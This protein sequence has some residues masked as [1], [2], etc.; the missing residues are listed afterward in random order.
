MRYLTTAAVA[1]AL[2]AS[3]ASASADPQN[4]N[5]QGA[6]GAHSG[7]GGQN[8]GQSG[9]SGGQVVGGHTGTQGVAHT[10]GQGGGA[11]P[12][13]VVNGQVHTFGGQGGQTN[14]GSRGPG[15]VQGSQTVQQSVG[16]SNG[17][18]T[19]GL[20]HSNTFNGPGNGQN[21]FNGGANGFAAGHGGGLPGQGH[22]ERSRDAG[23]G[24]FN[25]GA[26]AHQAYARQRFHAGFNRPHGWYARNWNFG[27]FLPFGWFASSY[28]LDFNDY[29]LPP[30]PIG[31]EWVREGDDAVLV[32]VWTGEVLSVYRGIFW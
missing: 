2:M 13:G 10:A 1:L 31:C 5:H 20:N 21:H 3:A 9:H 6:N 14:H 30:P 4:D 8:G 23:R 32:N 17:G 22:Q 26:F 15:V 16:Q 18:H 27:D 11:A 12:Q 25:P 19:A 28:Y 7:N 29:D 24:W